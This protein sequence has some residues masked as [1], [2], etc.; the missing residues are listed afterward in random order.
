MSRD[1]VEGIVARHAS[2]ARQRC[3]SL[4]KKRVSPHVLRHTAAM[5]LLLSGVD[6]TVIALWLGHEQLETTQVYIAAN[7][8]LK[9]KALSRT[10]PIGT[11]S[12][13]YQPGDRPLQFLKSL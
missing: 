2:V 13:R 6:R 3:P 8:E 4:E 11:R 5:D 1:A 12:R 9:E 10:T 7:L